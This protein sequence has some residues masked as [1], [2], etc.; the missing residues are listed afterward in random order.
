MAHFFAAIEPDPARRA[1]IRDAV[2]GRLKELADLKIG[3]TAVGNAIAVWA[4]LDGAPQDQAMVTGVAGVLLGEAIPRGTGRRSS[5]SELLADWSDPALPSALPRHDGFR[6]FLRLTEDTVAVEPDPLGI[7][8]VFHTVCAGTRMVS[9]SPWLLAAHPGF[10]LALDPEGVVGLLLANSIFAGRTVYQGVRRLDAGALLVSDREAGWREVPSYRIPVT[11][12]HHHLAIPEIVECLDER[13]DAAVNRCLAGVGPSLLLLSGGLD[14]RLLAGFLNRAGRPI[15]AVTHGMPS[16]QDAR[17]AGGVARSCGFPHHLTTR[18]GLPRGLESAIRWDGLTHA[19]GSGGGGQRL[20]IRGDRIVNGHLM[21]SIMGGSHVLAGY[22]VATR[23]TGFDT[24]LQHISRYGV[25]PADLGRLLRRE[26]FG[27]AL[28]VVTD[29]IRDE[30]LNAGDSGLERAWRFDI[31][32]RQRLHVG[33]ALWRLAFSDWPSTP[34]LDQEVIAAVAGVPLPVVS[35]RRLQLG[36]LV[37]KFPRLASL[38]IDRDSDDTRAHDP[39]LRDLVV[40]EIK[41]RLQRAGQ[42]VLPGRR[43]TP[44]RRY[45]HRVFDLDGPGWRAIRS[46]LEP[47]RELANELFHRAVFST[48]VPAAGVHWMG[49]AMTGASGIRTLL[50]MLSLLRQ[51]R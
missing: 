26:V 9:S 19:P 33:H 5:A 31:H 35:E 2:I 38:P 4:M 25:S 14:S 39:R 46:E 42:K 30:Y 20:S 18:T 44:E 7:F 17:L 40:Q 27:D 16:D 49:N 24:F 11:R 50:G 28:E 48:L 43:T 41:G 29:R 3:S 10:R 37:K 47:H 23:T 8:P 1:G 12:D 15:T 34:G 45:Y 6:L 22:D 13:L 36:L 51:M 32:H 21:D